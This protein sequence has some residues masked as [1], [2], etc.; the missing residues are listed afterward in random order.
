LNL[1]ETHTVPPD[2]R[3]NIRLS[4]YAVGIFRIIPTRKGIK[5]AIKKGCVWINAT[6]G[7]RA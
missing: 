1:L 3:S 4:D 7:T 5:K 2:I 6:N